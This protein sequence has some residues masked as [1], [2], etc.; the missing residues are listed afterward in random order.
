M[1]AKRRTSNALKA[2][3]IVSRFVSRVPP[4]V[5]WAC[6]LLT[7]VSEVWSNK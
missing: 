3:A 1:P 2:A 6:F 4:R 5:W 7:W